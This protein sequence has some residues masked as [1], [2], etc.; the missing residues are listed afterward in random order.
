[1]EYGCAMVNWHRRAMRAAIHKTTTIRSQGRNPSTGTAAQENRGPAVLVFEFMQVY[2]D[3]DYLKIATQR[4][5]LRVHR[6]RGLGL[7][8]ETSRGRR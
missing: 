2:R 4:D 3:T 5:W 8:T 1:M 7:G 6:Q